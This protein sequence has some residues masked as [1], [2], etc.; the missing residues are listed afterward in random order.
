MGAYEGGGKDVDRRQ[1]IDMQHEISRLKQ[2]LRNQDAVL[3][4]VTTE[5]ENYK[6]ELDQARME[7]TMV[8]NDTHI[9]ETKMAQLEREVGNLQHDKSNL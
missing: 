5:R 4:R 7:Q 6:R 8:R 1:V 2:D 9:V 3:E